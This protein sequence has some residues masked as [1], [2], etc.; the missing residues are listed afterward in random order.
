MRTYILA[1]IGVASLLLTSGLALR[2][3]D[4]LELYDDEANLMEE[5]INFLR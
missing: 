5:V 3:Y 2:D 4:A 1:Y